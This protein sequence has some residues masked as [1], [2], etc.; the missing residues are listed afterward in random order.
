MTRLFRPLLAALLAA[1]AASVPAEEPPAAPAPAAPAFRATASLEPVA[2]LVETLGA[3]RWTCSA[4]AGRGSDPHSFEPTPR[5]MADVA[6]SVAFFESGMP[7]EENLAARLRRT[8][9]GL[10]IVDLSGRGDGDG[11]GDGHAGHHHGGGDLHGWLSPP[12]LSEFAGRVSAALSAA[13]PAGA[14]AYAEALAAYRARA[15]AVHAEVR[16]RLASAGVRAFGAWHPAFGPF[17]AAMGVR[18]VALEQDGREPSPR[19]L[20]EAERELR[21]LGARTVLVQNDAERRRVA[22]FARRL[23][24]RVAAADPL[25]RDALASV[26]ALGEALAPDAAEEG[27]DAE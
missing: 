2:G 20:A 7:F 25:G 12:E 17:A 3:G 16:A 13:D 10:A 4:L 11:H 9:P 15:A 19:R 18:Q 1:A 26:R 22:P 6:G 27:K 23:S 21:E 14:A 8:R 24:L 5:Q